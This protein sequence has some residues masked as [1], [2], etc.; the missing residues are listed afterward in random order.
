DPAGEISPAYSQLLFATENRA[1]LELNLPL[2]AP[3]EGWK[4][5]AVDVLTGLNASIALTPTP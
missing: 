4:L 5:T 2:N 1:T 3:A